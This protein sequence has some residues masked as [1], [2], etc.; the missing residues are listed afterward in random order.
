M[1]SADSKPKALVVEDD[2][3]IRELLRVHRTWPGS[4]STRPAT[5]V[6]DRIGPAPNPSQSSC[7]M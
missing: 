4:T 7:W 6:K 3:A 5:A 2:A 1:P